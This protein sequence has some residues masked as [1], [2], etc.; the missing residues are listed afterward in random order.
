MFGEIVEY[1]A[2]IVSTVRILTI[3]SLVQNCFVNG[4]MIGGINQ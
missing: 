3:R 4:V 1:A 2:I